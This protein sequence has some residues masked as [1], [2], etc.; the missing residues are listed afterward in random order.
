MLTRPI[1]RVSLAVL[2]VVKPSGRNRTSTKNNAH[3]R[4]L[5][6]ER[7]AAF[8]NLRPPIDIH[9]ASRVREEGSFLAANCG[10]FAGLPLRRCR[11]A[12]TPRG[13]TDVARGRLPF[14]G[15]PPFGIRL[16][17]RWTKLDRCTFR[18]WPTRYSPGSP[19]KPGQVLVDGTL[20]GGGHTRLLAERGRT[21]GANYWAGSRSLRRLEA[22]QRNLALLPVELV[23]A[24]YCDLVEVLAAMQTRTAVDGVSARLG[25]FQR[26]TR[27]STSAASASTPQGPLDLRFN[28][29]AG[30]PAWRL[31]ERLSAKHLADLIY[32]FGEE[33]YSRRIAR[34]IVEVRRRNEPIRTSPPVGL[35]SLRS[36][37][38]KSRQQRI[39][40]ATRTFQALR[41]AVNDEL[42]SLDIALKRTADCLRPGGRLVII[43]F[44]SLEDRRVKQA[45][46][47]DD[48]YKVLTKK[49]IRPSEQEIENNPRARSARLRVAERK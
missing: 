30:E 3:V 21:V 38:P 34:K 41:I 27:R 5:F 37:L 44:H 2:R 49:P 47:E 10:V 43:S 45:F 12:S 7:E 1:W 39:D 8:V 23:Q 42:K 29:Q 22:A 31:I 9:A 13:R 11:K 17:R 4:P 24:N 46:R 40:P 35:V 19:S 20:G 33:R 15:S 32:E 28:P 16:A 18:S 14:R 6:A 36:C 48:R 26:S 25:P